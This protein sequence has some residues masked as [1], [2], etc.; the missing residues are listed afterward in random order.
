MMRR[1]AGILVLSL[2]GSTLAGCAG[3]PQTA[4]LP[5]TAP[6]AAGPGD[7][8]TTG[9]PDG[10]P[11]TLPPGVWTTRV[12]G[13]TIEA[14]VSDGAASVGLSCPE[15]RVIALR[16]RP[17]GA[18]DAA[19]RPADL[20][21]IARSATIGVKAMPA[22]DGNLRATQPSGGLF[23]PVLAA[24]EGG[25]PLEVTGAG[26]TARFSPLGSRRALDATLR[27]NGCR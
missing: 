5:P 3:A 16:Y 6:G 14:V 8:L 2:M 17:A 22:G 11:E 20:T 26:R 12:G 21:L 24:V 25:A 27:P 10:A 18:P 7:A 15:P 9:L 13:G 23:G 1:L 19:S 4:P